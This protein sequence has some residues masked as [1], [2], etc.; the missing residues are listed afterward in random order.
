MHIEKEID[1][2]YTLIESIDHKLHSKL[3]EFE[4]KINALSDILD[5]LE[6]KL[7]NL[8]NEG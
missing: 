6:Q 4:D 7:R 2:L 3:L 5:Q 8:R 1:I